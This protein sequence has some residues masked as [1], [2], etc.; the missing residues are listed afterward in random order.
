MRFIHVRVEV[1]AV[2]TGCPISMPVGEMVR[3]CRQVVATIVVTT[4]GK[5]TEW[6][7]AR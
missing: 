2:I 6:T 3:K 4:A 5:E 7:A 1:G